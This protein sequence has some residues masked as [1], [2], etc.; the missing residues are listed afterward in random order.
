MNDLLFAVKN[1]KSYKFDHFRR[2][3][4]S[5]VQRTV[6][7]RWVFAYG[8]YTH[9]CRLRVNS[10]RSARRMRT[11][12]RFAALARSSSEPLLR[13]NKKPTMKV[14]FLSRQSLVYHL[15]CKN[16]ISSLNHAIGVYGIRRRR[17]GNNARSAVW[18]HHVVLYGINPKENA[19][20]CVMPCAYGDSILTCG[21][22]PYQ[23]FGLDK[24]PESP[25]SIQVFWR[26]AGF[27]P[28]ANIRTLAAYE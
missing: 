22:I 15:F 16:S 6:C 12:S 26:E 5:S 14:G 4:I 2:K 19:R 17:H 27:S 28:V 7:I 20:W 24:K 1:K 9:A 23:S 8:E 3:C 25:L 18:N 10:T 21:E 13:Q 11:S